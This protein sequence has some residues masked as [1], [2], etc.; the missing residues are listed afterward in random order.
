[1]VLLDLVT[2][3]RPARNANGNSDHTRLTRPRGGVDPVV[4]RQHAAETMAKV[5]V[6][7]AVSSKDVVEAEWGGVLR[8]ALSLSSARPGVKK[9]G[10]LLT[11][12]LDPR[13]RHEC[14]L[15]TAVRGADVVLTSDCLGRTEEVARAA[16][17][18]PAGAEKLRTAAERFLL[19]SAGRF[20]EAGAPARESRPGTVAVTSGK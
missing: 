13:R 16:M 6:S 17:N 2:A 19:H 20:A 10:L 8:A 9:I 18:D 5:V 15:M 7:V 4:E 1:M 11:D 14:F 12:R 3:D